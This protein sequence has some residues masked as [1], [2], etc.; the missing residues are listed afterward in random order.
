MRFVI[1]R[2]PR[3]GGDPWFLANQSYCSTVDFRLRGNDEL[4][5]ITN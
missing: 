2:H 4:T 3:E 5:G 1:N